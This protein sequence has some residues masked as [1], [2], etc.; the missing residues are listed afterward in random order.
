VEN[1]VGAPLADQS[2]LFGRH[3]VMLCGTNFDLQVIRHRIF[4]TSF[5]LPAQQCAAHVG[6]FYSPAGHG[7]PNWKRREENPH[8]TGP[9]YADRCRKAMGIDWMNRD[10]LAQ[11]A[12]PA[13]SE[14][15]G[16]HL[17]DHIRS[18]VAA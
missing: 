16:Q 2:D 6:E 9:G 4:E 13:Y 11:A 5:P 12:P 10:E 14:W 17:L 7:D 8:L 3:G 18:E 1:V 15:I